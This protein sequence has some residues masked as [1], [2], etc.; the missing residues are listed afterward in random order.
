MD[1]ERE[2][3]RLRDLLDE[4][5]EAGQPADGRDRR[6]ARGDPDLG[7]PPRG[8]EDRVDVHERLAHPH[9]HEM[10]DGLRP[11][12]VEHLVEDLPR[13]EVPSEGHAARRAER[14]GQRAAGLRRDAHRAAPIPVAHQNGLD[15]VPVGGLEEGLD[16]A[17]SG[18]LLFLRDQRRERHFGGERL[19]EHTGE[20]RHRV[21]PGCAARCPVPGLPRAVARL[22]ELGDA[23]LQEF[24]VHVATVA[25]APR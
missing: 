3:D 17:V 10:V 12:E 4:R 16:G 7:Q 24:E 15:R 21:V 25:S 13:G 14:A 22:A 6:P 23:L 1:G 2:T 11:A 9:E 18:A 19:S 20:I 8:G 5:R